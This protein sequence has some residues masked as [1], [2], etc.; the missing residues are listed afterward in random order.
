MLKLAEK[1]PEGAGGPG[2]ALSVP[3]EDLIRH[4]SDAIGAAVQEFGPAE[5]SAVRAVVGG[6]S[7]AA[8][9]TGPHS[10][11]DL[12]AACLRAALAAHDIPGGVIEAVEDTTGRFVV[13]VQWHPERGWQDDPFSKA[14]FA[15][16]IE[17][18]RV[19]L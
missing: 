7:G 4:L 10:G 1:A 13:G 8:T 14:L 9:D 15:R 2:N 3:R 6:F 16:F 17:A 5:R 19:R 11:R 12:A 18:T